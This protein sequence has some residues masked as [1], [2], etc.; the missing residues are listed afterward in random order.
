MASSVFKLCRETGL[1]SRHTVLALF[2]E[3][4]A[5][6]SALFVHFLDNAVVYWPGV[7]MTL[8]VFPLFIYCIGYFTVQYY[9]EYA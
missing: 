5:L 8:I 2:F 9:H 7:I 4:L 6:V 1:L 3:A